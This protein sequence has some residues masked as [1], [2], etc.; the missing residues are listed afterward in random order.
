L[1]RNASQPMAVFVANSA[2]LL[3]RWSCERMPFTKLPLD[4]ATAAQGFTDQ[5]LLR[6]QRNLGGDAG[7]FASRAWKGL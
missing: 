1:R 3:Q 4:A 7:R 2:A 6:G 5:Q